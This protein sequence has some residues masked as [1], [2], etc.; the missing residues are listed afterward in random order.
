MRRAVDD[1]VA[2]RL[3]QRHEIAFGV[4]HDL[5]HESRAFLQHPAEQVRLS[6]PAVALHEQPGGQQFF[7]VHGHRRAVGVR[8]DH[9]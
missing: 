3:G 8:P 9:D 7:H 6:G 1:D 5:L 4:D 2:E